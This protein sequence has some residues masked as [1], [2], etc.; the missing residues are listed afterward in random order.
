MQAQNRVADLYVLEVKTLAE[1]DMTAH[2]S[3]IAS[4]EVTTKSRSRLLVEYQNHI[5]VHGC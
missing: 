5:A 3:V 4:L 2:A 1:K